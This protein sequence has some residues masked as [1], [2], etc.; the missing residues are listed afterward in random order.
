MSQ[1]PVCSKLAERTVQLQLLEFLE[2]SGQ[3]SRDHHAY[4]KLTS[5]TTALLKMCEVIAQGADE[6]MIVAT[7]N[8]DQTAAFDSVEHDLLLVKMT[9]YNIGEETI[10][11][12]R[13]YLHC[14]SSFVAIGSACSY[15]FNNKYGV[16]QGLCLG[17]LL[18]MIYVNEFSM[19]TKEDDC[20][21]DAHNDSESLF[22]KRMWQMW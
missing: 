6:N 16:P 7:M 13:S 20:E 5:T 3:L 17:P 10:E 21:D 4:R 14:R 18:Y 19:V 1:L 8:V 15:I 2:K 11:W 9:Y 12:I 22:W